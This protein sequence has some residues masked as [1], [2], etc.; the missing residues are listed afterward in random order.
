M[1]SFWVTDLIETK[2]NTTL[3]GQ[4]VARRF[5]AS[6]KGPEAVFCWDGS[7]A[8]TLG[9]ELGHI[10]W[11]GHHANK[12]NLMAGGS[13]ADTLA[14]GATPGASQFV[15]DKE[16]IRAFKTSIYAEVSKK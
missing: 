5:D 7:N 13:D 2:A 11:G 8:D 12:K 4:A 15:L 1:A 16:Q 14:P 6:Y 3:H 9:H 10:L